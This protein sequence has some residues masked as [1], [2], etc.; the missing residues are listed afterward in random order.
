MTDLLRYAADLEGK[1]G[2]PL[3]PVEKW[4]PPYRGDI[5]VVIRRDGVWTHEGEPIR[6][7]ELVRLF[8]TVLRKEGE[9]YFLVTPVEKLGIAVEDAP[10]LAVLMRREVA[11]AESR[12]VV[13]TNVGEE[14]VAGPDHPIRYVLR[15]GEWA[16][17]MEVRAG[18]EALISR[19]VFYD[20]VAIG[21]PR[22][23]GGKIWFGVS[24]AGAF[25]PFRPSDEIFADQA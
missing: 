21:E 23:I 11:G 9:R 6:R 16:P 12:I 8:S 15:N 13:T 5:D 10:F 25:F 7:A 19:A 3:P 14:I 1:P 20:L 4:D 24:S 17:Y 2:C 18:L 22:E